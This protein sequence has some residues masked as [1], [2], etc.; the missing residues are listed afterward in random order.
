MYLPFVDLRMNLVDSSLYVLIHSGSGMKLKREWVNRERH[1][2]LRAIVLPIVVE[3]LD[4]K[5]LVI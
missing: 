5:Y 2:L 1:K 3:Y 4:V